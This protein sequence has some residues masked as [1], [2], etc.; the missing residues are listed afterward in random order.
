MIKKKGR[1]S[2]KVKEYL[3]SDCHMY[4]PMIS[5]PKLASPLKGESFFNPNNLLLSVIVIHSRSELITTV[6]LVYI[7]KWS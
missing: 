2:E 6:A 1:M 3:N 4:G 7:V 5:P